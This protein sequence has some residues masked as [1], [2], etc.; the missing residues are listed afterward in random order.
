LPKTA[1]DAAAGRESSACGVGFLASRS[2]QAS[3]AILVDGLAALACQEHRGAC[4]AHGLTRD[5]AGVMTDIPCALLGLEPGR[6]AVATLFVE[7]DEVLE[8]L[9]LG[10]FESTLAFHGPEITGYR[11]VPVE[12]DVLGP[13]A[14][15]TL[16]AIKHLFL[17][18]S[19]HT[20]TDASFE[21]L[22]HVAKRCNRTKVREAGRGTASECA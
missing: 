3:H 11:D 17:R 22:L 16:P 20:R 21:R 13:R 6:Y 19:A 9:A 8:R 4:N 10:V 5:G 1:A 7:H 14:R 12:P 15:E 18:R 2:G